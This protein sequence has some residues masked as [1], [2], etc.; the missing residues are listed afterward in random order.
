M[1]FFSKKKEIKE[2]NEDE[3]ILKEELE[4]EVEKLQTEFRTKQEEV[5]KVSEKIQ[6]VKEEYETTVSNLMLVK[7]EFNQKKNGI[8]HSSKRIPRN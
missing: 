5:V 8:G 7:K 4:T 2:N 3:S 1:G 6:T